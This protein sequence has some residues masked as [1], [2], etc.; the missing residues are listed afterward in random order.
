MISARQNAKSI[1][2]VILGATILAFGT[3][4]LNYQNNVSEGG[5]LG[6]M[7]LLQ[8]LFNLSPSITSIV[9][10]FTLFFIGMRFFGK[11]FIMLAFLSTATFSL[12][13]RM[14]SSIGFIIPSLSSSMI[15]AAILSGIGVGV[16]VGLVIRAGGASSGDDVIAILG[17]KF[18]KLKMA[19]VYYI[20]DGIVLA[21]SLTY[22]GV[23]RIIYSIIAAIISGKIISIICKI[24]IEK[25]PKTN[26]KIDAKNVFA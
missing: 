23:D 6:L 21:L 1:A 8:N 9:I 2:L 14:W 3:Y 15:I 18:T 17:A 7:L 4:N 16:G 25:S 5:V 19:H 20:S 13:Y 26:E 12:T 22:L 24:G 11:R 10:D